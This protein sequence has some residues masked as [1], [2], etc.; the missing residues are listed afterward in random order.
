MLAEVDGEAER[1]LSP[2]PHRSAEE[3]AR[4]TSARHSDSRPG[5]RSSPQAVSTTGDA[6][7]VARA[8]VVGVGVP[9]ALDDGAGR[10]G[11]RAPSGGKRS[12]GRPLLDPSTPLAS[13]TTGGVASGSSRTVLPAVE[14]VRQQ[15]AAGDPRRA[16]PPQPAP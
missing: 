3:N 15:Q 1:W 10:R 14:V 6:A 2:G 9:P 13:W 12:G 4:C 11:T 8:A 16:R 5:T 7:D